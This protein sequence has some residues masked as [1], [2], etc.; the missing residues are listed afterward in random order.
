[1]TADNQPPKRPRGRPRKPPPENPPPPRPRGRP[2]LGDDA[3]T[4]IVSIRLDHEECEFWKRLAAEQGIT[5]VDF[6]SE[7]V[8][9]LI[10]RK[11]W[12]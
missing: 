3:K 7:P 6:I 1:M 11:G 4:H 10:K 9:R 5:M 8:R 12:K 2:S